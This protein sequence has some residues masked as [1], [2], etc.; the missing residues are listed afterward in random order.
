MS[1]G[2]PVT[3]VLI[4]ARGVGYAI[5]DEPLLSPVDIDLAAGEIVALRGPN[6]SGKTTLLRMLSG[7]LWPTSGDAHFGEGPADE[8]RP[9]MR[10]AVSALIGTPA[11]YPDLTVREQLQL[12]LATWGLAPDD[13]DARVDAVL[14]EFAIAHLQRRFAH[15][16]SSGQSQLYALATAF[17]RPFE[18][19]LLD[20]PEQR[21]D[22]DR[23]DLLADAIL[24][25]REGGA[26]ILFASH[27][28]QLV[29]DVAD[30]EFTL[31]D[32]SV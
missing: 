28:A 9:E 29:E 14:E 20:E 13:A 31:G 19:L 4:R 3:T 17:V 10:A 30:R 8:R 16:L 22:A 21:L 6:G 1:E 2:A 7:K 27:D 11:V 26:A 18:I 24:R 12:I 15:E 23:R 5:D 32:G 25:A